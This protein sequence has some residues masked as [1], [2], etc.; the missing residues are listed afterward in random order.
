MGLE[1]YWTAF[2][3]LNSCR[4]FGMGL[5]PIPHTAILD[6]A[7]AYGF[8]EDQ[9]DT[10]VFHVRAMDRAYLD[11]NQREQKKKHSKTARKANQGS[12]G[13]LGR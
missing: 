4:S 10:L 13:G 8:S 11:Y 7:Q 9:F 12:K 5:G 6:Y 3:E 1:L 2:H